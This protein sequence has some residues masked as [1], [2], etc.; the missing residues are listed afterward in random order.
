MS[1]FGLFCADV[2][3]PT[4]GR[5]ATGATNPGTRCGA[6]GGDADFGGVP[7]RQRLL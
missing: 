6:A 1:Q 3:T 4:D 5:T 2:P 7:R